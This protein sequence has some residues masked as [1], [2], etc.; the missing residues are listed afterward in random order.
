MSPSPVGSA[1]LGQGDGEGSDHVYAPPLTK[2]EALAQARAVLDFGHLKFNGR[3][4]HLIAAIMK[5][6]GAAK[7]KDKTVVVFD[8]PKGKQH[9]HPLVDEEMQYT[10]AP[11]FEDVRCLHPHLQRLSGLLKVCDSSHGAPDVELLLAVS[12]YVASQKLQPVDGHP[13]RELVS[14]YLHK[15]LYTVL[16][17]QPRSFYAIQALEI[18]ALHGPSAPTL[19]LAP[20][21]DVDLIDPSRGIIGAALNI[22]ASVSFDNLVHSGLQRRDNQDFWLWLGVTA[23]EAQAQLE[24]EVPRKRPRLEEARG[25]VAPLMLEG[26]EHLWDQGA[27]LDDPS[28][29]LGKLTVCDRLARL[30]ELHGLMLRLRQLVEASA[31]LPNVPGDTAADVELKAFQ[32]TMAF[33]DKR[34]CVVYGELS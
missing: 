22:S 25:M 11:G 24:D 8:M 29:L 18:L 13:I 32:R 7:P 30:D 1:A 2:E 12:L 15:D 9:L 28:E 17:K 31:E 34:H 21:L 14:P 4:L 16:T 26:N 6:I 33:L 27:G 23:V 3:P 19:P 20:G 10:L 5:K